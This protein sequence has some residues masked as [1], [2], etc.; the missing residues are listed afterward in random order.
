MP[1]S[2]VRVVCK[3][4]VKARILRGQHV[5]EGPYQVGALNKLVGSLPG[6][7]LAGINIQNNNRV[8]APPQCQVGCV[9]ASD[10]KLPVTNTD[11][12]KLALVA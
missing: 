1:I 7:F 10:V 5:G 9:P 3:T 2:K 11:V 8:V 4:D 6:N 12:I